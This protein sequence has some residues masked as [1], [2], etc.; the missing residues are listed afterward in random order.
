MDN[1]VVGMIIAV[2]FLLGTVFHLRKRRKQLI[3]CY[4]KSML[5]FS[6]IITAAVFLMMA[7]FIRGEPADYLLAL[8]ATVF[9][10]SS[11]YSQGIS[12]DGVSYFNG[13][14]FILPTAPWKDINKAVLSEGEILGIEFSGK[15][16]RV[17]QTYQGEDTEKI[18]GILQKKNLELEKDHPENS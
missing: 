12:E 16:L 17:N 3:S 15:T 8:S 10:V 4:V 13:K 18:L 14:T 6:L 2:L 7:H 5:K 9:I 1:N 11:I